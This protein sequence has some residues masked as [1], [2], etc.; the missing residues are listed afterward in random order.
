[1]TRAIITLLI[2]FVA[3]ATSMMWIDQPLAQWI[4]AHQNSAMKSAGLF[5]EE[6]GRSHWILGYCIVMII[7]AWRSMRSLAHKHL[8][9]FA[10]VAI[11]G[12][13]ANVIKVIACRPRPPLFIERGITEWN[14]LG[15]QMDYIW[16]SFPSGHAT[17]GLAIAISGSYIYPRL[18]WL[19]WIVGLAIA[20]GRVMLNAHYLSDM[21]AGGV[22]GAAVAI[23]AQRFLPK[24]CR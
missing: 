4:N 1:M 11:S 2:G 8:A 20:L 19:F 3:M 16:N 21:I 17:T 23:A 18:R 13:A 22:I 6:I 14:F 7:I 15:F 5:L 10:S 24:R 12:I 9:L